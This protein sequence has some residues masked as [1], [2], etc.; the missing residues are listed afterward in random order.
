MD[1]LKLNP[2]ERPTTNEILR[3]R[4]FY[5]Y[6]PPPRCATPVRR[7]NSL[8]VLNSPL[9][10]NTLPRNSEIGSPKE[11]G[12]RVV[13]MRASFDKSPRPLSGLSNVSSDMSNSLDKDGELT[14]KTSPVSGS[15]TLQSHSQACSCAELLNLVKDQKSAMDL[16]V[17]RMQVYED[18]LKARDL[19]IQ[20]LRN[21][22]EQFKTKENEIQTLKNSLHQLQNFCDK[23]Q[24]LLVVQNKN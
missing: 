16:M 3:N 19:E 23:V 13:T 6:V 7:S 18:Q 11:G 10:T 8:L 12:R 24:L 15:M 17:N 22:V 14:R 4:L 9:R 20:S 5:D 2:G 21:L 1:M